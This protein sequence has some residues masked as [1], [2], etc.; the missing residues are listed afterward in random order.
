MI[1]IRIVDPVVVEE[2]V[3]AVKFTAHEHAL[4]DLVPP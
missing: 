4:C 2:A 1:P 3:L